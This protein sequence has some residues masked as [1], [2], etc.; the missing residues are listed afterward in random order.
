MFGIS[1][2][3]G[4]DILCISVVK[5]HCAKM[6]IYSLFTCR[7]FSRISEFVEA[8][9]LPPTSLDLTLVNFLCSMMLGY[10]ID[11]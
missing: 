1:I 3:P 10:R 11:T 6:T 8:N 4:L 7:L 5:L 9:I 2:P